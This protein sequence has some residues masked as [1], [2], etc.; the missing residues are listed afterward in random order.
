M[1][2]QGAHPAADNWITHPIKWGSGKTMAIPSFGEKWDQMRILDVDADGDLD[3]VGNIEEW[4][5]QAPHEMVPFYD[6]RANPSSVSVV[7]FEN[8]LA[9]EPFQQVERD[10]VVSI[11]A[12][13][14]LRFDDGSWVERSRYDGF[15][16]DGYLQAHHSLHPW[17]ESPRAALGRLF[18]HL[19]FA[20]LAFGDSLGARYAVT[21]AGGSYQ[22]W[23]RCF[24][25]EQWGYLLGGARSNA[26]FLAADGGDPQELEAPVGAR[27]WRW[28]RAPEPLA[29]GAGS[30]EL[31]LRVS[32]RG[33]A[34]DRI[35]LSSQSSFSPTD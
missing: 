31:V 32:E 23:L 28:V 4:W 10:G 13:H 15:S 33:F 5:V 21:V 25:P 12:E 34:V 14:A 18:R 11:E 19:R 22:L 7:W 9:E 2:Y 24:V 20:S 3:I 6:P 17:L 26:V 29:L 8:R 27:D 1:Q 30:H 16:G 35:V